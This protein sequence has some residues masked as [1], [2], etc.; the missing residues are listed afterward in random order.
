MRDI[1]KKILLQVWVVPIALLVLCSISYGMFISKLGFYWDDW[2]IA[3][4]I[5]FY[6]PSSFKEAFANDRP[7]LA[8]IYMITTS[9]LGETPFLWHIFALLTRWLSCVALWWSLKGL[10]DNKPVQIAAIS[11]IFAIYPG[12]TQQSVAITYGNAFLVYALFLISLGSMIWAFRKR[13]WFW[14]YYSV[15]LGLT[16]YSLFTAEYFFG[17]ELL[18]PLFL[19]MVLGKTYQD[20]RKRISKVIRYWMPYLLLDLLFLVWRA[21]TTTPRATISIFERLGSDIS[22]TI[23]EVG[24][25]L[26]RDL[27]TVTGLAWKATFNFSGIETYEP[28]N[29][30]KYLIVSLGALLFTIIFLR[31]LPGNQK[32]ETRIN[33][34]AEF[35]W[36]L[37]AITIG[38]V[39][40]ILAGIPFWTT[41]L[42]ISLTFPRDRYTLPFMMG[43]AILLVGIFEAFPKLIRHQSIILVGVAV[44]LATGMHFRTGYSYYQEW[45][46]QK[47]FFWELSWR[48]PR[49]EPGSVILVTEVPFPYDSDNSLSP[50]VNWMYSKDNDIREYEYYFY[51]IESHLTRNLENLEEGMPIQ[52]KSRLTTF[53]GSLSKAI[54]IIFRGKS[55]LK[56][57]DPYI[58]QGFPEKP[59]F[60]R[61]ILPFSKPEL[62]S[63]KA[64][65]F[66][67]PP[68]HILGSEPVHDWCYYFEK[69]DLAGQ[70]GNWSEVVNLGEQVK[71][72]SKKFYRGNVTE[73]A[74]FIEGYARMGL[75]EEAY[76]FSLHA[77][78]AWENSRNM[79]CD[80]WDRVK[81]STVYDSNGEE[82]FSKVNNALGCSEP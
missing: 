38:I 22:G 28:I 7:L 71:I 27:I 1:I 82:A 55:C 6:G 56:V 70:Q 73:L 81:Q 24:Q 41:N 60:F 9:I 39:A 68:I 8:Y 61:E 16:G 14:F 57:I 75:W 13:K 59:R 69:A 79:V 2:S 65:R 53:K 36:A 40:L 76:Q 50:V 15:S 45:L 30:L 63:F 51:N 43:S 67:Q 25:S 21:S 62:I 46:Q 3:Y 11:F 31:N 77:Y 33:F 66:A 44:G 74:P 78:N 42:P 18:R 48:A 58:D 12:F 10:W 47:R 54:F 80:I 34:E 52:V 20:A 5:H 4:Y 19:W 64:D 29:L 32:D 35:P 17:L 26:L 37:Q 49:I 23:L 72:R